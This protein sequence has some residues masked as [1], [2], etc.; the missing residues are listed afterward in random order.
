MR[1][2]EYGA[3][4][5]TLWWAERVQVLH[6]VESDRDW[7]D[8]L[9]GKL[10]PNTALR[11]EPLTEDGSYA[12]SAAS[13][14]LQF[15]VIVIDGFDRNNCAR[16]CLPALADGGVIVWDNSDWVHLFGEGL[17]YLQAHGFRRLDFSGLGPLNGYGWMTSVF[18]RSGD[19]CLGI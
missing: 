16:R 4:N 14:N 19:N 6:S 9:T 18:Y 2:F 1:V 15:D 5:S 13:R 12:R 8:A 10:S 17:S 7:A 3:G 11:H